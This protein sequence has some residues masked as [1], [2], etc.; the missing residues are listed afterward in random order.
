MDC[1]SHETSHNFLG[2]VN[3]K[4]LQ[5]PNC[6]CSLPSVFRV[7]KTLLNTRPGS[8]RIQSRFGMFQEYKH[9]YIVN[10]AVHPES[11]H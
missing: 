7:L 11:C 3:I 6:K 10:S 8:H 1:Q 9:D 5:A 4:K 2:D